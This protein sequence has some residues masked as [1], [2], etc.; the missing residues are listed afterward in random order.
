MIGPSAT[1]TS[2]LAVYIGF[3]SYIG[4]Q[5][6]KEDKKIKFF[7]VEKMEKGDNSFTLSLEWRKNGTFLID[8]TLYNS[9]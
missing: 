8:Q 6:I 1:S 2:I 5:Y 4:T 3:N 9:K 7:S